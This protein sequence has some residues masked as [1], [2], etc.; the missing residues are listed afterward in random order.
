MPTLIKQNES[1]G[2]KG[3]IKIKRY[4]GGTLLRAQ[5]H[6]LTSMALRRMSCEETN[7]LRRDALAVA[8]TRHAK[9]MQAILDEGFLETAVD[10]H[11]MVMVGALT[12]KDLLVQY[13]TAGT[14]YSGGINYGAMGTGSTAVA[15]TDTQLTTETNRA[16]TTF[17]Q[18]AGYNEAVLQFFFPDAVLSNTTFYECGTFMNATASANSGQIFNHALFAAPYVKTAG[19]DTTLEV[20]ITLS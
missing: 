15:A 2:A 5:P 13:L 6:A 19:S 11:N 17:A 16:A 3:R 9:I 8:S 7:P 18:D 14:T 1:I 20:D 12:G 10:Q 4:R